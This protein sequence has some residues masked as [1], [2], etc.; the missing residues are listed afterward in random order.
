MSEL[1][2]PEPLLDALLTIAHDY[3][4]EQ[5][6]DDVVSTDWS[7]RETAKPA[8]KQINLCLQSVSKSPFPGPR[9]AIDSLQLVLANTI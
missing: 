1:K 6:F 4:S 2:I 5:D 7:D 9:E 8:W 3:M